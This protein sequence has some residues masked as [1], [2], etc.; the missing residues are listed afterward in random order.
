MSEINQLKIYIK[1]E[2]EKRINDFPDLG[3][4]PDEIKNEKKTIAAVSFGYRNA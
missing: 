1:E 2:M 3:Y 4:G